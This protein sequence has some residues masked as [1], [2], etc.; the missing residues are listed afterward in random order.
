MT[1]RERTIT[2]PDGTKLH[3]DG[4]HAPLKRVTTRTEAAER[5]YEAA[6]NWRREQWPGIDQGKG[7]PVF[8]P[9]SAELLAALD[10]YSTATPDALPAEVARV[11]EAAVKY[12]EKWSGIAVDNDDE[13]AGLVSAIRAYRS[14][15]PDPLPARLA[16][17]PEG[18]AVKLKNGSR[19][20]VRFNMPSRQKFFGAIDCDGRF[21]LECTYAD[22]ES[23]LSES[24]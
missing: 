17:L 3:D 7:V 4:T 14:S 1:G 23:I 20:Y 22:V 6:L 5:L 10:A 24:P 16:R 11:V 18:A 12:T 15:Q 8:F 19:M 13:W 9:A 2:M 21:A